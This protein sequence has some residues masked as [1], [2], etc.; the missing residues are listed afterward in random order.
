MVVGD[1]PAD[2][3]GVGVALSAVG[4][5]FPIKAAGE[6]WLVLQLDHPQCVRIYRLDGTLQ[7]IVHFPQGRIRLWLDETSIL[8][9]P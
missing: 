9:A 4:T 2:D 7:R 6:Q 8:V 5:S 1:L 3:T